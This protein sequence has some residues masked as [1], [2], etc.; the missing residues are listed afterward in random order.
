MLQVDVV[1]AACIDYLLDLKLSPQQALQVLL[2]FDRLL[3]Q[4]AARRLLMRYARQVWTK[5]TMTILPVLFN[6]LL[7]EK[8]HLPVSLCQEALDRQKCGALCELQVR[9]LD[10]SQQ[11]SCNNCFH[12]YER[13]V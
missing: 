2:L 13:C 3:L 7:F 9:V 4:D 6:C 12:S 11:S 8:C 5:E 1:E 10:L